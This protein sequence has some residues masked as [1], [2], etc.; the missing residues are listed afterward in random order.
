MD[1]GLSLVL[2]ALNCLAIVASGIMDYK[3]RQSK[4]LL[5]EHSLDELSFL[6]IFLAYISTFYIG[7]IPAAI[8]A[9]VVCAYLFHKA[10]SGDRMPIFLNLLL[11]IQIAYSA[12]SF[13]SSRLPPG[14]IFYIQILLFVASYYFGAFFGGFIGMGLEAA[15]PKAKSSHAGQMKGM[16][17]EWAKLGSPA[18]AVGV[19]ILRAAL[20][21]AFFALFF[22]A[23]S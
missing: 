22:M 19:R 20:L 6:G 3:N 17:P 18:R 8:V 7:I 1:L 15:F 16:P 5:R 10:K 13:P 23:I 21:F 11:L 12:Y 9:A 4:D 14:E 2:I